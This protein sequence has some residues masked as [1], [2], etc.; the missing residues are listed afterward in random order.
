MPEYL[1]HADPVADDTFPGIVGYDP[2]LDGV[3]HFPD[4]WGTEPTERDQ[5]VIDTKHPRTRD[6][7]LGDRTEPAP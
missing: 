6:Y 3:G 4:G 7:L 1:N 2:D 5:A